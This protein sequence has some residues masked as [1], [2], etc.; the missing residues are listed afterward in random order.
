[1]AQIMENEVVE[2]QVADGAQA[3]VAD[4]TPAEA[5]ATT[6]KRDPLAKYKELSEEAQASVD[7]IVAGV[8]GSISDDDGVKLDMLLGILDKLNAE[9]KTAREAEKAKE[10]ERKEKAK[11]EQKIL[12]QKIADEKIIKEGDKLDYYMS[13]SKVTILQATVIK[14]TDKSARIDV[15]ADSLVLF[16]G[17]EVKAGEVAG[18]KLGKKPVPFGKVQNLTRNGVAVALTSDETSEEAVA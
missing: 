12:A 11:D 5:P 13:T 3:Q 10:K 4:E 16:K 2:S 9:K 6:T 8:I 14:V 15:T 7:E 1:M 18:F 17:N